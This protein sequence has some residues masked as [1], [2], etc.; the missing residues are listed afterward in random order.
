MKN[1]STMEYPFKTIIA[2]PGT[3]VIMTIQFLFRLSY[4]YHNTVCDY[5]PTPKF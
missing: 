3:F 2:T 1:Y 4:Q 5:E